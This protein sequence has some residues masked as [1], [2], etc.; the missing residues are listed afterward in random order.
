M[1]QINFIIAM[2]INQAIMFGAKREDWK[3]TSAQSFEDKNGVLTVALCSAGQMRGC[4]E[5]IAYMCPEWYDRLDAIAIED[6]IRNRGYT[7][8]YM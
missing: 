6:M 5:G 3:Q 7:Q 2:T 8:E 4:K 1:K